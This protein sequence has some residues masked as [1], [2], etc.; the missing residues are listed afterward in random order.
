[1]FY[2]GSEPEFGR[3]VRISLDG[4]KQNKHKKIEDGTKRKESHLLI[5]PL[6]VDNASVAQ[7][8]EQGPFKPWVLGSSPSGGTELNL[9]RNIRCMFDCN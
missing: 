1:M 5:Y 3:I 2:S 6:L 7:L 4:S 9:P 8:V